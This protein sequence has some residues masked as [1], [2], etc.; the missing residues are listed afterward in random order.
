MV[1]R[2]KFT[3]FVFVLKSS[4]DISHLEHYV[5]LEQQNAS[6]IDFKPKKQTAIKQK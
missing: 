6:P 5:D 2:I 4:K 3:N 1:K